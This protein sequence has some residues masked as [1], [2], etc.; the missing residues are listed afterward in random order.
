MGV[1]LVGAFMAWLSGF[2]SAYALGV[3]LEWND[4]D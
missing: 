4:R 1:I 3:F 2:L